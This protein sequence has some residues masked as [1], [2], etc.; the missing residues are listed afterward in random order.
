MKSPAVAFFLSLI[1]GLGHLYIGRY[2]RTFFYLGGSVAVFFATLIATFG[3]NG[4]DGAAFA[5]LVVFI[6]FWGV[7]MMDMLITISNKK[8]GIFVPKPVYQNING[9]IVLVEPT[10]D[11]LEQAQK[12]EQNKVLFLSL[13]P[14]AAHLYM[15]FSKRGISTMLSFIIFLIF[16]LV[17]QNIFFRSSIWLLILLAP[18][19]LIYSIYDAH[20]LIKAKQNDIE[21]EDSYIFDVLISSMMT[22]SR[23]EVALLF[24][25]VPGFGHLVLGYAKQG[26]QLVLIT[27]SAF[28]LIN[29]FNMYFLRYFTLLIWA[30]SFFDALYILRNQKAK[31]QANDSLLEAFRSYKRWI[32]LGLVVIGLY[33]I[34]DMFAVRIL[35]E[36]N[37]KWYQF[38][39]NH[40]H[41]MLTALAAF[42]V[43]LIGVKLMT[44]SIADRTNKKESKK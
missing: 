38:Y 31:Q 34:G 27:V 3:L 14:G 1:P 11:P 30:Y 8:N 9:Q 43:I 24:S 35:D 25:L 44:G 32:G 17:V 7:N 42:V 40:K 29:D 13:I 15:N 26:F 36:I 22:D 5:G 21:V 28:V 16:P 2:I 23:N 4:G 41:T 18:I 10:I 12:E 20:R 37:F 19:I 33:F 6:L 39:M